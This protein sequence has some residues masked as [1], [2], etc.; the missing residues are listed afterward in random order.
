MMKVCPELPQTLNIDGREVRQFVVI[1]N[2][3]TS[4]R[5]LFGSMM[6]EAGA[7]DPHMRQAI[8]Q[9]RGCF[10]FPS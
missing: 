5:Q 6:R 1:V 4:F 2:I 8:L 10:V 3:L 7:Y 9:I